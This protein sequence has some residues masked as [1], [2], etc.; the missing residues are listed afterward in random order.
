M[1]LPDS[2]LT[3]G[4]QYLAKAA[5][6]DTALPNV[7]LTRTEQYLAKIAG[8]DVAIPN[9]PL[10]RLE[11]YLAAIAENGGGSSIT[12]EPLTAIVNHTYT[13]PSGKAYNPVT[14]NVSNKYA[15]SDI[16][17][18]VNTSKQLVAQSDY[19]SVASNGTYDT[20][21]NNSITVNVEPRIV[22]L[23]DGTDDGTATL[24][25][26]FSGLDY[27]SLMDG[28][29]QSTA[30][31]N[32]FIYFQFQGMDVLF[33]PFASHNAINAMEFLPNDGQGN[34]IGA[35]A[36]WNS[37]GTLQDLEVLSGGQ[38]QD[39]LSIAANIPCTT[40]IYGTTEPAPAE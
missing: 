24:A 4:E 11:Q 3:R 33:H 18:V 32:A 7:P 28:L 12:V 29:A 8:Q 2:P 10:T 13:A 38:V 16:G 26:P 40:I 5:G 21:D 6:Q 20:T 22:Y 19:G 30:I 27:G 17:K 15:N 31:W 1:A 35:Y 9:V 23:N 39:L 37:N 14:V 34:P 25:N 36:S